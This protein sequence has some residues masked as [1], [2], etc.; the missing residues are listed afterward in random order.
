[1]RPIEY[2][3]TAVD[4][5]TQVIDRISNRVE[6]LTQ[7][8]S[9]LE[10]SVKRFGDIT[11]INKLGKG[12]SWL[13]TKMMSLLGVVLKLGAPLLALFGGGTIAGIYQMT[14]G[15]AKLGAD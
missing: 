13:T 1:M 15:W 6:R 12:I 3:I 7:P 5:A 8:F 9:R 14:E 4:R 2:T 10:R 11:G